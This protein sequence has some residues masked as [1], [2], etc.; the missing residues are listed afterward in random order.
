MDMDSVLKMQGALNDIMV[1]EASQLINDVY[2]SSFSPP[3]IYRINGI[4]HN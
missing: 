2:S 3:C 1:L 4:Q